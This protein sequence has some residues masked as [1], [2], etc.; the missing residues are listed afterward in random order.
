MRNIGGG[1][2]VG[3]RPHTGLVREETSLDAP[4][5]HRPGEPA[6]KRREVKRLAKDEAERG[7]DIAQIGDAR[8]DGDE[9]VGAR[10]DGNDPGGD[11]RDAMYAAENHDGDRDDNEQADDGV[12]DGLMTLDDVIV[13]GRGH[14]IGLQTVEPQAEAEDEGD[15][16]DNAEPAL[17]ERE[18]DVVRRPTA[19][20]AIGI[21]HLPDLGERGLDERRGRADDGHEPHPEDR[22]RSAD[23]DG[24]RDADDVARTHARCRRDHERLERRDPALPLGLRD[25][26]VG[27][28]PVFV[29]RTGRLGKL[30]RVH[31]IRDVIGELRI[32][33]DALADEVGEHVL[34]VAN[35]DE[36]RAYGEPHARRDEQ[37]H[38]DV[39]VHEVIDGSREGNQ[40]I[41]K[42]S[43]GVSPLPLMRIVASHYIRNQIT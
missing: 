41:V 32:G 35:L 4:H 37:D 19:K 38:Q 23:G 13:D 27:G 20:R 17:S 34:D 18:L 8:P 24:R 43:H 11:D 10:H 15:R 33:G 39:G 22:T 28:A 16:E 7:G 26:G 6:G 31:G 9:D 25:V 3:R 21:A 40:K 30:A 36:A 29:C 2:R 5:D 12:D 42:F 1:R 14:V